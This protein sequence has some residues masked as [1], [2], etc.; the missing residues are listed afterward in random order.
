MNE[1]PGWRVIPPR[2][3]EPSAERVGRARCRSG[4]FVAVT[5]CRDGRRGHEEVTNHV[6]IG[7]VLEVIG[8]EA[9][10]VDVPEDGL[11]PMA[12]LVALRLANGDSHAAAAMAIGRSAK[13]CQRRLASDP[14]F[15]RRVHELKAQRVEEAAAGLG[16]LLEP[17]VA[18]VRRAL[19][20]DRT[21]DQLQ[22]ARLVF[23]RSRLFRSDADL[24]AELDELRT[25]IAELQAT[26]D[27]RDREGGAR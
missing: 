17:A 2:G 7:R 27:D 19:V 20:S 1:F 26:L 6:V 9:S 12:E 25:Q 8:M 4:D 24:V 3:L 5:S 15:R 11:D 21:G 18:A 23:D 22:A 14:V 16:A 10:E 13:W